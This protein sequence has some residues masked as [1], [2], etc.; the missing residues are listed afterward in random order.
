ML[1]LLLLAGHWRQAGRSSRGMI[2]GRRLIWTR[3][4]AAR[5]TPDDVAALIGA[6]SVDSSMM[7]RSSIHVVRL[8][9]QGT[10]S[11]DIDPVSKV[12]FRN[13]DSYKRVRPDG[14]YIV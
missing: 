11:H 5:S 6:T 1:V 12:G 14:L 13:P 9:A 8:V 2:S 7:S 3:S 4:P 10:A